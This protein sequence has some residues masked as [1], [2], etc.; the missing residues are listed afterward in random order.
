MPDLNGEFRLTARVETFA[1]HGRRIFR[2]HKLAR[3]DTDERRFLATFGVAPVVCLTIWNLLIETSNLPPGSF[4]YHL[5]WG[6][7]FLKLYCAES[8]HA[9]LAGCDEKTFRK[10]SWAFVDA[11]S[12]LKNRVVSAPAGVAYGIVCLEALSSCLLFFLPHRFCGT[13][14]SMATVVCAAEDCA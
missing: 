8:I 11:I 13:I 7:M 14:D 4:E 2:K 12:F 5:L 9:A 10:W 6:L 3:K 1:E